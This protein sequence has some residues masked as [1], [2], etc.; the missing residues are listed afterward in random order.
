MYTENNHGFDKLC[1]MI[2]LISREMDSFDD[3]TEL[4]TIVAQKFK[5]VPIVSIDVERCFFA[6]KYMLT[7][8]TK[9]FLLQ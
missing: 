1:K 9:S 3:L 5:Y 2:D 6:N 7:D 4:E 8:K